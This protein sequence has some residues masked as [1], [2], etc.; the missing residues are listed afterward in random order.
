ME[1]YEYVHWIVR[2][3]SHDTLQTSLLVVGKFLLHHLGPG[4]FPNTFDVVC[5][6][7]RACV[8]GVEDPTVGENKLHVM[9][10]VLHSLVISIRQLFGNGVEVHGVLDL[11]VVA[12]SKVVT[13][14]SVT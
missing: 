14:K 4:C 6:K 12:A 7:A 11:V 13:S 9:G 8:R 1:M 5:T 2:E 3:L 10:K